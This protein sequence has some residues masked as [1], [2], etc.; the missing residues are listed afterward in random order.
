M[1]SAYKLL[2]GDDLNEDCNASFCLEQQ[3]ASKFSTLSSPPSS[4]SCE[5]AVVIFRIVILPFLQSNRQLVDSQLYF[6]RRVALPVNQRCSDFS[7]ISLFFSRSVALSTTLNRSVP[8]LPQATANSQCL[9]YDWHLV[10]S[11]LRNDLDSQLHL[12]RRINGGI[13]NSQVAGGNGGTDLFKVACG[14]GGTD[15]FKVVDNSVDVKKKRKRSEKSELVLSSFPPT[16]VFSESPD[17][18]ASFSSEQQAASRFSTLSFPLSST[19]CESAVV[20]FSTVNHLEQIGASI[21]TADMNR[22]VPSLPQVTANSQ[23][24][25]YDWHLVDSYLRNDRLLD[26]QLHLPRLRV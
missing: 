8:P 12:P 15:L 6:L 19:S 3:A 26:S 25:H 21:T 7:L 23:Y 18:N 20:R 2:E 9:H 13:E 22:S 10:H 24:L 14:N 5:S 11:Y 1:S 16:S 4:T 17:C